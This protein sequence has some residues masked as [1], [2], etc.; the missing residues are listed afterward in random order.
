[1][2]AVSKR[3]IAYKKKADHERDEWY[4]SQGICPRCAQRWCKPGYVHCETCLAQ[5]RAAKKRRDPTGVDKKAYDRGR[6]ETLIAQ[7]LCPVCG[8]RKPAEGRIEC[9]VC[10]Q[11]KQ[12]SQWKFR[13]KQRIEREA[14]KARANNG[15]SNHIV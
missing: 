9:P 15:N 6:R 4:K 3:A 12:D 8:K 7:G 2:G 13:I 11:R 1:M 5:M 14:Q 10:R